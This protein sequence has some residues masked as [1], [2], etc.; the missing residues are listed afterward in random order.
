[1]RR[2]RSDRR[3]EAGAILLFALIFLT[4]VAFMVN[5]LLGQGFGGF[6]ATSAH[7]KVPSTQYTADAAVQEAMSSLAYTTNWL[8][9]PRPGSAPCPLSGTCTLPCP[10][11]PGNANPVTMNGLTMLASCTYPSLLT[12]QVEITACPSSQGPVVDCP[13][14]LLR[15][16]VTLSQFGPNP[17]YVTINDWSA[18][19][20]SN[21]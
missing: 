21:S 14:P 11:S 1:M 18:L 4:V 16:Y 12:H 7:G 19:Y 5:A 8:K 15:A 2:L 13:T 3:D 20:E 10:V 6:A 9:W 17:V